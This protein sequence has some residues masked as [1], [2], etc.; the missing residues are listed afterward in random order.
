M[1]SSTK[2]KHGD[3]DWLYPEL[4]TKDGLLYILEQR[5][6]KIPDLQSL[7]K[8][9]LLQLYYKYILPL[10]QRRYR[11]NRRGRDL[12]KKQV[13]MAKKRRI[14]APD[15]E[16]PPLKKQNMDGSDSSSSRFLT[17]FSDPSKG[18]GD[19]LKPPPSCIDTSRKVIKLG[20]GSKSTT[21][22][23]P[24]K[25]TSQDVSTLS[26]KIVKIT[27]SATSDSEEKKQSRNSTIKLI[28]KH[29][30]SPS[31][32]KLSKVEENGDVEMKDVQEDK[33]KV[34]P[35]SPVLEETPN[36]KSKLKRISWP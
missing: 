5:Y 13:L 22:A 34:A 12:T 3:I 31:Q 32:G 19:R 21:P 29:L 30:E 16:E 25:S 8:E 33:T 35:D 1:A 6:I 7:D 23:S 4:L 18:G 36:K 24:T 15:M 26:K 2:T 17:S 20:S 11:Q 14:T 28:N 27:M 9:E 10:P